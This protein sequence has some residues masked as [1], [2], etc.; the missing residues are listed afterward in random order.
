MLPATTT[1]GER[2]RSSDVS[3]KRERCWSAE[4]R[5]PRVS[6]TNIREASCRPRW[7]CWAFSNSRSPYSEVAHALCVPCPHS[8]GH[9]VL[10]AR[11]NQPFRQ[12][13]GDYPSTCSVTDPL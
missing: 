5:L 13:A 12:D 9:I 4:W 10:L 3:M 6:A 1:Q 8:C 11:E 2:W 7:I